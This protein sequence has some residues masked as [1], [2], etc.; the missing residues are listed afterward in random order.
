VVKILSNRVPQAGEIWWVY[1][2]PVS[3][4]EQDG[5]RPVLVLSPGAVNE[6][7][8]RIIGVSITSTIRGWETEV[9]IYGLPKP[10]VAQPDQVRTLDYKVRKAEFRDQL[11]QQAE[12]EAVKIVIRALLDL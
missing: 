4:T 10:C 8:G 6:L 7:T 2:G 5:R 9:P 1:L 12:L 3:G 11:V